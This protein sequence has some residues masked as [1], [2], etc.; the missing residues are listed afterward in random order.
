MEIIERELNSIPIIEVIGEVDLYNSKDLKDL[1]DKLI[2][3]GKY[4][5]VINLKGVPF[6]DSSGI[7]TIVTSMY[8]LQKYEG[9]LK[10]ASIHGSVAKVFKMTN[11]N[12][13]IEVYG[14]E[15]DAVNSYK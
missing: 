14:N 5:I 13:S 6:M 7:G 11:I 12:S 10:V 1:I 4:K 2:Q 8:K 3:Q 15:E 9:N